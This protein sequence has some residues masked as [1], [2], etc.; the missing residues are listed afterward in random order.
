MRIHL[1]LPFFSMLMS[2]E[3]WDGSCASAS[4]P[5]LYAP[6]LIMYCWRKPLEIAPAFRS[7]SY[8]ESMSKAKSRSPSVMES[9][10]AHTAA[11]NASI[12]AITA[13]MICPMTGMRLM[14]NM[15]TVA[16]MVATKP[17]KAASNARPP[18]APKVP[19]AHWAMN[20]P[21]VTPM[22]ITVRTTPTFSAAPLTM[23]LAAAILLARPVT[24]F[25]AACISLMVVITSSACPTATTA[26]VISF[27]VLLPV[28]LAAMESPSVATATPFAAVFVL[29]A[30]HVLADIRPFILPFMMLPRVLSLVFV[31]SFAMFSVASS[32][33]RLPNISVC[34]DKESK[35]SSATC[36]ATIS[37]P[38][39]TL[40]I[41]A[42]ARLA[43]AT[44]PR[45]S[46][47][48][49]AT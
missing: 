19:S 38:A 25:V 33:K 47:V 30:V 14:A 28:T 11:T 35:K 12:K 5:S 48:T 40:L 21:T 13:A 17:A 45:T 7:L 49:R 18:K 6:A 16:M 27:T 20:N 43:S 23:P 29:L 22:A 46:A 39:P 2:L 15:I 8:C 10:M 9:A 4:R 37:R 24:P 34:L 41:E 31:L 26:K 32:S 42:W 36:S 3:S 44:V 1:L